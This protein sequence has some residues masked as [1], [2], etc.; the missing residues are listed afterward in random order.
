[1]Q[2]NWPKLEQ[3]PDIL[4]E[5]A[6][7]EMHAIQTS[8]N[9]IRNTTSDHL[10][11]VAEDELEDPRPWCEI[12]RQW[13]TFHPE[14]TY[15]PRKFKI[16]VTGAV[17]R[18]RRHPRCTT[19]AC[20]SCA[21]AGGEPGFR[22][23]RRRR[24]RPHAGHRPGGARI[25]AARASA[26]LSG[27]GAARLQP[28]G[29]ARQHPQGADQDPGDVARHRGVPAAGGGRVGVDPGQR[30]DGRR[31]EVER[32][33]G[34]FAPPSYRSLS[35]DADPR[36]R[37]GGGISRLVPLQHQRSQDA[38]LSHRVHI[39]QEAR[40]GARAMRPM[41]RWSSSPISPT[42]TASARCA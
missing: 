26:V 4:A 5:L 11:G 30:P 29:P 24:P 10:A 33:R 40:R 28:R 41:R 21:D 27:G 12:I 34:F 16:A 17:A 36:G 37:A 1:M 38:G 15:L 20:T 6:A 8:G 39:A 25:P 2:Y 32:M 3:V 35:E 22:D 19:S 31:G 13:S 42:A 9:C 23:P 18:P 7:V 14:F